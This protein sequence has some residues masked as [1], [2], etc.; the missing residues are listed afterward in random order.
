M[1]KIAFLLGALGLLGFLALEPSYAG[2]KKEVKT[3][4]A[5][6]VKSKKVK[7]KKTSYKRPRYAH[8]INQPQE[9]DLLKLEGMAK[10]LNEQ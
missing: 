3:V 5:K 4:N 2:Q 10:D 1:R 7:S 9:G 6:K 8:H